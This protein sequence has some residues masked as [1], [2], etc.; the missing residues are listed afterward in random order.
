MKKRLAIFKAKKF[1]KASKTKNLINSVTE[2]Y[3]ACRH[4][5][6]FHRYA[7]SQTPSTDEG[8][9]SPERSVRQT[10]LYSPLC[11]HVD[12][13]HTDTLCVPCVPCVPL[14]EKNNGCLVVDL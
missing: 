13:E 9:T 2:I 10:Y 3:G 5:P 6:K 12:M 8:L 1:D 7:L 11:S 14:V 4:K